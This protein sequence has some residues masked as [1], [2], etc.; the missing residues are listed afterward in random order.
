MYTE[1]GFEESL[2]YLNMV[3]IVS[4]YDIDQL[5][6]GQS[7]IP[8]C[9][10][11]TIQSVAIINVSEN[12][13]LFIY[14]LDFTNREPGTKF[15]FFISPEIDRSDTFNEAIS[16]LKSWYIQNGSPENFEPRLINFNDHHTL[17]TACLANESERL[18][19]GGNPLFTTRLSHIQTLINQGCTNIPVDQITFS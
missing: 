17:Y 13:S 10:T 12:K 3:G 9:K 6:N 2:S 4:K 1:R 11:P 19:K 18:I 15:E 16:F 7:S 14:P 8:L 5:I